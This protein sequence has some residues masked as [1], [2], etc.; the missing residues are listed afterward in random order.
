MK[1]IISA[2]FSLLFTTSSYAQD[3]PDKKTYSC[4]KT[5][6]SIACINGR[7]KWST[8]SSGASEISV[9]YLSNGNVEYLLTIGKK[10]EM[11]FIGNDRLQCKIAGLK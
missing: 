6:C 5:G 3:A 10:R 8:L 11:V 7:N 1:Y 4:T 2:L 9:K